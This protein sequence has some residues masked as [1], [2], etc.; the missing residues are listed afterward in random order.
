MSEII[1]K[2][3][4]AIEKLGRLTRVEVQE[5]WTICDE[6]CRLA[7]LRRD[8]WENAS[9]NEKGHIIWPKGREV[10]WFSQSIVVPEHLYNYPLTGLSL[11]LCLT[12]WAEDALIYV[13]DRVAHQ[14]DLF[15]SS[16]RLLLSSSVQPGDQFW[17]SLRL[18]S[19]Q[20]DIGALMHSSLIYEITE[21]K[22]EGRQDKEEG[23]RKKEEGRGKTVG[24]VPECL[25]QSPVPSPLSWGDPGFVADE[26][27]LIKIFLSENS[28]LSPTENQ[29][30]RGISLEDSKKSDESPQNSLTDISLSPSGDPETACREKKTVSTALVKETLRD[31]V[32]S[33]ALDQINWDA[34]PDRQEF[35]RSLIDF[36]KSL[37]PY[38]NKDNLGKIYLIGHSHLDLAWLWEIHETWE[39]AKNTF[40]SV[41]NL[42]KDFP[43][44]L[45]CHTTP[46]LYAWLEEN[47]PDLFNSIKQQIDTGRWEVIGGLWVEPELNLISGESIARQILYGQRYSLEKFGKPMEIAWLPDTFGF[48]WQLPQLLKEGGIKFFVTQKLRWNDTTKFPH[49]IFWWE[50]PDGSRILSL[51]SAPIG[52]G[53]NPIKMTNYLG[54][55]QRK[56]GLANALWL[57]GVGDHGGG[58]TRDMLE[59]A[60][61]WEK[62]PFCP[63]FEFKKVGD[64]LHELSNL[65]YSLNLDSRDNETR[66]EREKSIYKER[67]DST[68]LSSDVLSLGCETSIYKERDDS[69]SLTSDVLSFRGEKSIY[70]ERDDST[71]STSDVLSL[72][73]ET[74]I[75]KERDDSI[76]LTSDSLSLSRDMSIYEKHDSTSLTLSTDTSIDKGEKDSTSLGSDVLSSQQEKDS[77][78]LGSDFLSS[79]PPK[80]SITQV[81]DFLSLREDTSIYK[82]RDDSTCSTSD[83]LSL[84]TKKD[85]TSL[86]SDVLF[87]QGDTSIDNG[88]KDSTSLGSDFLSLSREKDSTSPASDFLFSQGDTS[89]DNGEK[90]STSLGSDFL[91]SQP[92]KDSITQ[93]SDFLSLREDTSDI[94]KERDDSTCS[95]SNVLSLPTKKDSTSLASDVLFSQEDTSIDKSEKDSTSLGS[96]FLSLSREKDSTSPASDFL[97]LPRDTSIYEERD[98]STSLTSDVLSLPTE[99][100]STSFVSDVLFSEG[101]TSIDKDEKD[102][103][104]LASDFLSGRGDISIYKERD[105]STSLTCDTLSSQRDMSIYE[106]RDDSTSLN[107]PK[108]TSI[109]KERDDST[110]RA[111]DVLSSQ[112]EK[113][114][115]SLASDFLF[116]EGDTSIDKGEKDLTSLGSDFLSSQPPKDLITQ[117]GDFLSLPRDTSIDKERDDSTSFASDSLSLPREKDSTS[118]ASDFLF[119]QPPTDSITQVSD[120]LSLP[121]DT[122]I[123]EERDDLTSLA[124]DVLSLSTE[125]DSTSFASD[126]FFSQGDKSIDKGEKD[127]TSLASDFLSLPRETSSIDKERDDSTSFASDSSSLP[128]EKDSTTLVSDVLFSQGDTSI[129]KYEKDSTSLASDFLSLP[130]EKDST[131]QVNDV[132]FSQGDTSI[133]KYEERDDS[134]SLTSDSLSLG[135]ETSIYKYEERDD[136]TFW[137]SDSLSLS[138]DMSI[139][140]KHDSTSLTSDFLSLPTEKDSTSLARDVLFSQRDTSIN[141]DEKDST[142]LASDFLSFPRETSSID[143]ERDDSTCLRS[144]SLSLPREK[145]STS[146]ASDVLFSQGDTSINKG[147]KDSTPL[148]S[149]VLSSQPPKDL[150]TPV[151]DFLSLPRDTSI[152][153]E[154]DDSTFRASDSLSLSRDMS[155]YEKHDSTCLRSDSLSLPTEKDSTSLASDVLFSQGDT[156]IDNDEKDSTCLASDF[157]SSQ[158]EKDSTSLAHDFLSLPR[159]KDSTSLASD[160]LSPQRETSIDKGE[161]DS[162]S[163]A[164]DFLSIL[165][166]TSSIY[167]ERDDSISLTGDTLSL[168]SEISIDEERDDSTS[169]RSDVLSTRG[170]SI[171]KT[172]VKNHVKGRWD[173]YPTVISGEVYPRETNSTSLRSDTLSLG[174]ETFLS[175]SE[176]DSLTDTTIKEND[177]TR[178]RFFAHPTLT[179]NQDKENL[180]VWRDEL[181]LEFHRGCYTTHAEQKYWNRY[182]EGLLYEA[183]LFSTFASIFADFPYPKTALEIA[184]KQTLFNQFHDILPGTSIPEVYEEVNPTWQQVTEKGEEILKNAI[185]S[186]ASHL[187][188]PTP[189]HLH[190]KPIIVFNSLNWIRSEVVS[191]PLPTSQDN[192]RVYNVL[193]EETPTQ[194]SCLHDNTHLLFLAPY[195]PSLGYRVF[196]LTPEN[197]PQTE[198]C[199]EN[200]N[201]IF[202]VAQENALCQENNFAGQEW[203]L[204]NTALRVTIDEKTGNLTSLYDKA[205]HRETLNENG[206]NLLQAFTDSGQYWDAWNI[207]PNYQDYP[208]PAPTLI[209]IQ[210]IENGEIRQRIRVIRKIAN[211]DFCQDYILDVASPLLRI[212][213]KVN[214]QETH[215]FVKA[216]FNFNLNVDFV[217]YEI[218]SGAIAR[219]TQ[220]KTAQEKAKWE[221]SALRWADMSNHEYG[222][223]LLNN[224]KYGYDATPNQLRLSLLRGS[225]WPDPN[226]DQ[227]FHHFSYAVYPHQ[228]NWQ[229]SKTV[230]Q[231]YAFNLPL[232]V[233][234]SSP[235]LP[236]FYGNPI[237]EPENQEKGEGKFLDLGDES[238]V[239]MALKQAEEQDNVWILRCYESEGKHSNLSLTPE[240][241]WQILAE[242][243]LLEKARS[244]FNLRITPWQI[245]TF[246]VTSNAL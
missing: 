229:D 148:V 239:L 35:T 156:S 107:F 147:E 82:E 68:S 6:E 188:L 203:V 246:A 230:H 44:L 139:Y 224:C 138:R 130:T 184:W 196:W 136:S 10:L 137:A 170:I 185:A 220:P 96:D 88:E 216:A 201:F 24:V 9:R 46:A 191:I 221:V 47:Q 27:A 245:K 207:D 72:G 223:S 212:E 83:V 143:K 4:N 155:I 153:K 54:E 234:L 144:D 160:V 100:D 140:E 241:Q 163:L 94:Y 182:S 49:D 121:R 226:A 129:Y 159:E 20:H 176:L 85:S 194:L 192:F 39:V 8:E 122:S 235:Q 86:A 101:D 219:T 51:M 131:S 87:S 126:V 173:S 217:N 26:L 99:K 21:D 103:T 214:W 179:D 111:S 102:S 142:C 17:V 208:L 150:I 59:I 63:K 31:R 15:D 118:F 81:S 132:L 158:L 166:E 19:P 97:S 134:I 149:D 112:R 233:W 227:G 123:Y 3:S 127:S 22:E 48:C 222:V 79:Q 60:Y 37:L 53:I 172:S 62:S 56:T 11:R 70:K 119:S 238:L 77:T 98:D 64:Y 58:P 180:P 193:G 204:E 135:C 110:F 89:I 45:F 13:R 152:Y 108:N 228:G 16:V 23:R 178:S 95:T 164:S 40:T 78:S 90:D 36:H 113:D 124:S 116:S 109:Y 141:N 106:E 236:C 205:N 125:K 175:D 5:N 32:V 237:D 117:V 43:E 67:D 206:G 38:I 151:S 76:S 74:P 199:T 215:V 50:S 243:D 187:L 93:V 232:K 105:D 18:V 183:E 169:L 33:C 213:T 41:L 242:V 198:K 167:Q 210:W 91:S 168:Q 202:S 154:R 34:L 61:R 1:D 12:W 211:S 157:L 66:A 80:D 177:E 244:C 133:Y 14:G 128:R 225:T 171:H 25:P 190:A 71:S 162:T 161:K 84:P 52:E 115:T 195:I 42:Q 69:I 218:A 197:P 104:S 165:R 231:G 209:S 120:F 181:Y 146:L 75:Y 7:N 240:G 189:P 73:W 114:S 30:T 186:L 57:P 55:W 29:E 145:D 200:D 65:I 174:G 2:I 92:P 28:L